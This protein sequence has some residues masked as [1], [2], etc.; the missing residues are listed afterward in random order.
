MHTLWRGPFR[1]LSNKKGEYTLLNLITQKDVRYHMSQLKPFLF[2]PLHTDPSDVAR[3]DYLEF[4]IE[5]IIDIRGQTSSYGTL[6]FEVKW[7]NYP[8][9]NNTWEPWKNLRR[10]DKLHEFLIR[11]NLRHLIPREFRLDYV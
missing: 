9:E 7:L 10:T 6:E 3:R 4:F 8:S 1:V 11:K 5:E 2:D